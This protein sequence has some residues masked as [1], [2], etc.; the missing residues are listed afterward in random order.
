M[1][2]VLV[3]DDR[4]SNLR[5]LLR[6]QGSDVQIVRSPT[7]VMASGTRPMSQAA[8]AALFAP[9]FEEPVLP[10]CCVECRR[11]EGHNS[12]CPLRDK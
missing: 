5:R 11:F 8:V 10:R 7:S 4:D 2:K 1:S 3:V 6:D 12:R 9:M